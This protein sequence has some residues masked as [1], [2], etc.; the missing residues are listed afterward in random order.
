MSCGFFLDD[1]YYLQVGWVSMYFAEGFYHEWMWHFVRW[2]SCICWKHHIVLILSSITVVHH[3]DWYVNVEPRLQPRNISHLIMGNDS[4]N[5]LL[6]LIWRFFNENVGIHSHQAIALQFYLKNFKHLF[7]CL[8]L[9]LDRVHK[10]EGGAETQGERESWPC[11]T[12]SWQGP[13][14]DSNPR[15]TR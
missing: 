12:L 2:F 6:T 11:P 7:K 8:F 15:T 10:S 9:S 3:V 14:W 4:I 1:L 13:T 5:V